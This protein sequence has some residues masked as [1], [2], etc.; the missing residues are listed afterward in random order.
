V[1]HVECWQSHIWYLP[2]HERLP[3]PLIDNCINALQGCSWFSTLD[4][5]AGYHSIPIAETNHKTAFITRV[6][7]HWYTIMPFGL[8]GTPS[9]FQPLSRASLSSAMLY[10]NTELPCKRRKLRQSETGPCGYYLGFAYIATQR[11]TLLKRDVVFKWMPACQQAFET[12][13]GL[14]T[15]EPVLAL[16]SDWYF[17]S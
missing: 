7:C 9:I 2:Q 5:P 4:L 16:P 12:L 8:T 13:K 1:L 3:L 10:Q 17:H 14:L 15:N 11:Y 6:G